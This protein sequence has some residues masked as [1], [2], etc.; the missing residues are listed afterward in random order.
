MTVYDD[1]LVPA[2]ASC[3]TEVPAPVEPSASGERRQ[4]PE[5]TRRLELVA[6]LGPIS[7]A[8]L[9]DELGADGRMGRL[10][11][12]RDLWRLAKEGALEVDRS[13]RPYRYLA[14]RAS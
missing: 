11:V 10:A 3:L 1:R 4:A 6:K 7:A 12:T 14:K 13:V 5:R 8:D 9:A 2:C